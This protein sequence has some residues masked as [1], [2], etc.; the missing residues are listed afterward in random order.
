MATTTAVRSRPS[1]KNDI[2]RKSSLPGSKF[3]N[4][5]HTT[6][7]RLYRV[8]QLLTPLKV[9]TH[10]PSEVACGGSSPP[11]LSAPPKPNPYEVPFPSHTPHESR[12]FKGHIIPNDIINRSDDEQSGGEDSNPEGANSPCRWKGKQ[13]AIDSPVASNNNE[14]P[15]P[16]LLPEDAPNH[17]LEQDSG[18]VS[19]SLSDHAGGEIEP[20][21]EIEGPSDQAFDPRFTTNL[22]GQGKNKD[23]PKNDV[24]SSKL[25]SRNP[26]RYITQCN[27]AS[28]HTPSD[29]SMQGAVQ[30]PVIQVNQE[31]DAQD[32]TL[33][34]S[35]IQ[36]VPATQLEITQVL[37]IVSAL[38]LDQSHNIVPK[39]PG[40]TEDT[41]NL[42]CETEPGRLAQNTADLAPPEDQILSTPVLSPSLASGSAIMSPSPEEAAAN[43]PQPSS[44]VEQ[45]PIAS[46]PRRQLIVT[47]EYV[48]K[49]GYRCY[50]DRKAEMPD[51]VVQ[52]WN[53][54]IK[55]QLDHDI[56]RLVRDIDVGKAVILS[57]VQLCMVGVKHGDTLRGEPTIVITCGTKECK[58]KIARNL[59]KLKLHYLSEFGRPIKVRYQ[60]APSYWASSTV[61][62]PSPLLHNPDTQRLEIQSHYGLRTSCR[63]VLSFTRL[64]AGSIKSRSYA[65]LGGV[66]SI[67]GNFYGM[68][69]A[70]SFLASTDLDTWS[71]ENGNQ[72]FERNFKLRRAT[73]LSKV[74]EIVNYHSNLAYSFLGRG[75]TFNGASPSHELS[76]SDWALFPIPENYVLPNMYWYPNERYLESITPQSRLVRGRVHILAPLGAYRP[77]EGILTQSNVSIHTKQG[78]M[79]VREI[80]CDNPLTSGTSGSWVTRGHEVYGYV[81]AVTNHGFT[82]WMVP[83]E[84]TFQNIEA[85]LGQRIIFGTELHRCIQSHGQRDE[86]GLAHPVPGARLVNQRHT[87]RSRST[88][89]EDQICELP[90]PAAERLAMQDEGPSSEN[91]QEKVVYG[92]YLFPEFRDKHRSASPQANTQLDHSVAAQTSGNQERR[93]FMRTLTGCLTSH[94]DTDEAA[95]E[96]TI[97]RDNPRVIEALPNYDGSRRRLME[98]RRPRIDRYVTWGPPFDD[99]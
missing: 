93:K 36:I 28:T 73:I 3:E 69:T 52:R 67:G 4:S 75:A 76:V 8:R 30:S 26:Y 80:L 53:E 6:W 55:P 64:Q 60:P 79:D 18:Y 94:G 72:N 32:H 82:C 24:G 44:S 7:T 62:V 10:E 25:G 46:V 98:P 86:E 95:S 40:L 57:N 92:N 83:M 81:V 96:K 56:H 14:P 50:M 99:L 34:D 11:E 71:N 84:R 74:P 41:P 15:D 70:H 66:L 37:P 21:G 51:S 89:D 90:A 78:A 63:L 35:S 19:T 47:S 29:R 23:V 2:G 49:L 22:P 17:R 5:H 9:P 1:T 65:T 13:R 87:D 54:A 61:R 59:A 77:Y 43:L 85:A 38:K 12:R 68:T 48:E 58:K 31:S 42:Y 45:K 20:A 27:E 16:C 88:G 97:R 39:S 33:K 91:L